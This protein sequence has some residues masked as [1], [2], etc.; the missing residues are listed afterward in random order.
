MAERRRHGQAPRRGDER[1]ERLLAALEE[2]LA[3]RPLSEIGVADISAAAGVTRS[4]FYFYFPSKGAAVAALLADFRDAMAA[5]GAAWYEDNTADPAERVTRT[6]RASAELW[7]A[8]APLLV[9]MLDAAAG[10]PETQEIWGSWTAGFVERIRARIAADRRAGLV[11]TEAD[12]RALATLLMGA[13]LSAMEH[14]VRAVTAGQKPRRALL[15]ALVDL[16]FRTLY[17]PTSSASPAGPSPAS[18]G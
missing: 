14:E 2:L 7:R 9:A 5:A 6:V 16:W 8:H 11:H 12:A 3:E 18:A 17:A 1:R 4:G 10:G 15:D 13:T